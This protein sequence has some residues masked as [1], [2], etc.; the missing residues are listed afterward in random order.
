MGPSRPTGFACLAMVLMFS[1][2]V[3]QEGGKRP[4]GGSTDKPAVVVADLATEGLELLSPVSANFDAAVRGLLP[5]NVVGP[6]LGT[7][8]YLVIL[9][10]RSAHT[11]VAYETVWTIIYTDKSKRR[12]TTFAP[13]LFVDAVSGMDGATVL[14]DPESQPISSGEKRLVAADTNFGPPSK[15]ITKDGEINLVNWLR[16]VA[17]DQNANAAEVAEIQINLDATI[18][19][20]GIL[21]GPNTSNL[22]QY[23]TAKLEAKQKLFRQVVSD[24]DAGRTVEEALGPAKTLAAQTPVPSRDPSVIYIRLAAQE[25]VA[26]RRR[27]GDSAVSALFR[28]A[29]RKEPFVIKRSQTQ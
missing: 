1:G 21:V 6:A 23:F 12:K 17:Q 11:I 28:Q 7:K 14:S 13:M 22:D 24:L 5:D 9:S 3:A 2:A 20:D 18:F 8:P 16:A 27:I 26:L 15:T 25:I 19:S 10:N 29:I 4:S